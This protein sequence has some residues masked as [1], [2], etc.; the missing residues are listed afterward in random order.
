MEELILSLR[1]FEGT[2][3]ANSLEV[4]ERLVEALKLDL[5]GPWPARTRRGAAA[6]LGA[7][8]ELV[9]DRLP[10]PVGHAAREERRR[11]RGR[12]HGGRDPGVGG[13][14]RGVERGAQGRE[15]GLLPLLDGP[16]LPRA[17]GGA[18]PSP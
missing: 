13:P 14:R 4:R 1:E 8:L 5:V 18:Q 3:P 15:E 7:P 9:S 16:E 6:G 17:E 10:D 2:A 12:R 11:R